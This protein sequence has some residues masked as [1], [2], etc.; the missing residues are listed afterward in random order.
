VIAFYIVW[1]FFAREM[2]RSFISTMTI[3]FCILFLCFYHINTEYHIFLLPLLSLMP[4][5]SAIKI[6]TIG[7]NI[8]HMI[9]AVSTWGYGV[10]FGIRI[11][12]EGGSSYSGSKELILN[13]YNKFLGF[14]P[15][16][17]F[18]ILLLA[19]TLLSILALLLI[20]IQGLRRQ[21]ASAKVT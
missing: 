6:P 10:I 4:Y 15:I 19:L 16:K 12:A 7:F 20:T 3:S 13:A 2:K 1:K 5:T 17:T 11:F 9:L 14:I 18:E 8:T 21:P